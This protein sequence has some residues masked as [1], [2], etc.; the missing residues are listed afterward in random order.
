[1]VNSTQ[2]VSWEQSRAENCSEDDVTLLLLLTA[3]TSKLLTLQVITSQIPGTV[4]LKRT[5][6][7]LRTAVLVGS[8]MKSW[9]RTEHKKEQM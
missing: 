8:R 4:A 9:D 1:M 2:L 7:L 6:E 3:R 5:V